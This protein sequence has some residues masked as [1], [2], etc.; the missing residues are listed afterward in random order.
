MISSF[1]DFLSKICRQKF[2]G[3][4]YCYL[5]VL[6]DSDA[7]R[8]FAQILQKIKPNSGDILIAVPLSILAK[9]SGKI[10]EFYF[11]R[12]LEKNMLKLLHLSASFKCLPV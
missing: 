3:R 12:I 4:Q 5:D 8:Y 6:P 9:S 11:E 2:A 1:A 10:A 7:H